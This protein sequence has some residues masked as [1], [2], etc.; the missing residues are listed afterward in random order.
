MAAPSVASTATAGSD[1]RRET[2]E[3]TAG[4]GRDVGRRLCISPEGDGITATAPCKALASGETPEQVANGW[5]RRQGDGSAS[6]L[7]EE[8]VLPI[9]PG[10]ASDLEV[11]IGCHQAGATLR[12]VHYSGCAHRNVAVILSSPVRLSGEVRRLEDAL[13]GRWS[14]LRRGAASAAYRDVGRGPAM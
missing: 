11:S 3:S 14:E 4:L 13:H 6:R 10:V 1:H 12:R 8:V 7:A 9:V 2:T 5:C